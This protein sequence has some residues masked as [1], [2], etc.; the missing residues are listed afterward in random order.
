ML[1]AKA[2]TSNAH[3]STAGAT[4]RRQASYCFFGGVAPPRWGHDPTWKISSTMQI[5]SN[6][7]PLVPK[8]HTHTLR[9]SVSFFCTH[10][11][12]ASCRWGTS[13]R[14]FL[15]LV[16]HWRW[17]HPK[18]MLGTRAGLAT[19]SNVSAE[20]CFKSVF[21]FSQLIKLLALTSSRLIINSEIYYPQWWTFFSFL[22]LIKENYDP[23]CLC[24][25]VLKKKFCCETWQL[26]EPSMLRLHEIFIYS[27]CS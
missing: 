22:S 23:L 21:V 3:T 13:C 1:V 25:F 6:H 14:F 27:T 7:I 10:Y 15:S 9:C 11:R 17:R 18:R 2:S 16:L 5:T 24:K 12:F 20:I 8:S 26:M 4:E 19:T